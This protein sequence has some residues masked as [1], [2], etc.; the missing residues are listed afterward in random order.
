MS[1]VHALPA[2]TNE[3]R[4]RNIVRTYRKVKADPNAR[5]PTPLELLLE[6]ASLALEDQANRYAEHAIR[7]DQRERIEGRT[8]PRV[9]ET[10]PYE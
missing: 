1:N 3:D 5:L 8:E 4:L 2:L 10:V 9:G 7:R 6:A